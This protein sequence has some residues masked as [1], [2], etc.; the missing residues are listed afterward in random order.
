MIGTTRSCR[1]K[2]SLL[3]MV[4]TRSGGTRT[5]SDTASIEMPN[6]CPPASTTMMRDMAMVI[7]RS[8]RTVVPTPTLLSR[9]TLPPIWSIAVR[10]TSI[11]IP[12]PEMSDTADAVEKP[13]ENTRSTTASS[14]K[15]V[16]FVRRQNRFSEA[17][18][19][20]TAGSMPRP[21]SVISSRRRSPIRDAAIE[22]VAA[23]AFPAASPLLGIPRCRD[24]EHCAPDGPSVRTGG[25]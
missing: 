2:P 10:T 22:I 21:S 12:R 4:L 19:R 15:S 20:T 25:P 1:T 6:N 5:V 13:A 16:Q 11:P 8:S 3:L 24:R 14:V 7:G 23:S 17:L 9:E 18:R